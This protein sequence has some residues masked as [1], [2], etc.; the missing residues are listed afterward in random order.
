M[1]MRIKTGSILRL[2]VAVL[3]L[4]FIGWK[5]YTQLSAHDALIACRPAIAPLLA[6]IALM[7][8]AWG[9]PDQRNI[10]QFEMIDIRSEEEVKQSWDSFIHSHHYDYCPNYF[11]SSLARCP[12]RTNESYFLR[13]FPNTPEEA[14]H[15]EYPIPQKGFATFEEMWAWHQELINIETKKKANP[16]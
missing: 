12:R 13:C 2:I 10:E 15:E 5:V 6:A 11:Q 7:Q 16:F 9:A 14:F 8:D 1:V 4:A 3:S